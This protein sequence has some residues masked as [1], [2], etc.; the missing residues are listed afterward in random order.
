MK[1]IDKAQDEIK[2]MI[3]EKRYGSD[4]YLP[5]EGELCEMLKMSRST[6]REAVRSLEI[7][8]FL[9]RVH[10]KGIQVAAPDGQVMS[11]SLADMMEQKQIG[12]DDI[13]EV[14]RMIEIRAAGIA[15]EKAGQAQLEAM[16]EQIE[17]MDRLPSNDTQ[18]VNADFRFHH[19]IVEATGN[20]L[21]LALVDAYEEL[22]RELIVKTNRTDVSLEKVYGYH[23]RIY[24]AIRAGDAPRAK[25]CMEAHLN[26]TEELKDVF[27]EIEQTGI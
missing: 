23:R 15:A 8:G 20:R 4:G 24:D 25:S 11:R 9:K 10:G 21:L 19:C 3:L 2:K 1:L 16:S 12:L 17:T 22:L 7:R 13:L 6:I 14:R 18:Y 5:C 26:A 27:E